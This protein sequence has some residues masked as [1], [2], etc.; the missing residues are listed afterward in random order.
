MTD[1]PQSVGQSPP[2]QP[3]T[4]SERIAQNEA[5]RAAFKAYI[6]R[7]YTKYVREKIRDLQ[8]DMRHDD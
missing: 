2:Q 3:Q 4:N 8:N 6:D 1:N 7:A 5:K